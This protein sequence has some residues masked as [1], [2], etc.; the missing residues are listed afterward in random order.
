M[1]ATYTSVWDGGIEITTACQ[2]NPDTKVVDDI[3]D[4][5]VDGDS[6]DIMEDEYVT[7]P[8]GKELRVRDGVTFEY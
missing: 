5:G 2:Y 1:K 8:D 4:S 6:V 3:E 7:L